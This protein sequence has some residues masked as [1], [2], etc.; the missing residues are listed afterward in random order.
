MFIRGNRTKKIDL[1]FARQK[2]V[3]LAGQ[4][5]VWFGWLRVNETPK[6]ANLVFDRLVKS[7]TAKWTS[8]ISIFYKHF[9]EK[10]VVVNSEIISPTL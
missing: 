3:R 5:F 9:S 2:L 10:E 8:F 7:L 1:D 4:V 6:R